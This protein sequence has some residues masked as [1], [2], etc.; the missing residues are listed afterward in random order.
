MR[1]DPD[2]ILPDS[3]STILLLDDSAVV[4]RKLAADLEEHGYV[5]VEAESLEHFRTILDD[6]QVQP[7][8]FLLDLLLPDGSG[9]EALAELRAR[10]SYR[11]VP[12]LII[13]SQESHAEIES[14]FAAGADDYLPKP[15]IAAELRARVRSHIERGGTARSLLKAKTEWENTFNAVP[16]LIAIIDL[17]HRIVRLNQAMAT[18]MGMTLE[19]CVGKHC[20][21]CFHQTD[22]PPATC[23]FEKTI[24]DGEHHIVDIYEPALD[25]HFTVSTSPIY[26]DT[27]KMTGIV[28][29]ACEITERVRLQAELAK[30]KEVLDQTQ[31][32]ANVGGWDL[33]MKTGRLIWTDQV[34]RIF[35][36]PQDH[37]PD[38]E[39]TVRYYDPEYQEEIRKTIQN[40]IDER[41]PFDFEWPATTEKG[42]RIWIR[43]I[44]RVETDG[45]TPSRLCGSVQ[46]ITERKQLEEMLQHNASYDRM[47]GLKNRATILDILAEQVAL[48]KRHGDPLS[49]CL[50]DLDHFKHVNDT[51]GHQVGDKVLVRFAE[52]LQESIRESDLI[53]R[54]GGEEFIILLSH[55]ECEGARKCIQRALDVLHEESFAP[56]SGDVFGVTATFGIAIYEEGMNLDDLIAVADKALYYGKQNGRDRIV[57]PAEMQEDA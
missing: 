29:V 56:D 38:V 12:A 40:A 31:Q 42:R 10:E 16:D 1:S 22:S 9:R 46:D 45:D 21:T 55:T 47:T 25:G 8:L 54:Y 43:A 13:T 51:Y 15:W 24:R 35:D 34:W 19:E 5:L 23:P 7:C 49:V 37:V 57:C 44:G 27:G 36:L 50:A 41:T 11:H 20:F 14:C 6:G 32:L 30:S 28:H 18:R 33:D 26:D 48:A 52:I 17:D 4:R 3:L 2:E 53:G 39:S